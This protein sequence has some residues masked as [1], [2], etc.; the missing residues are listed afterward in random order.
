MKSIYGIKGIAL[1]II[2]LLLLTACSSGDKKEVFVPSY[3]AG[4]YTSEQLGFNGPVV[5]EVTFTEDSIAEIVVVSNVETDYIA[6]PAL[7]GIPA[8]IIENQRLKVDTVSG[9]TYTSKAILKAVEDCIIQAGENA[10]EL[11][12]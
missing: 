1:I 2:L 10:E 5:I 6:G 4:T 8:A 9:A 11:S 3:T 12:K 7:E